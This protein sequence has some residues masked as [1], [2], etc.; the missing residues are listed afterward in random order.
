MSSVMAAWA[1]NQNTGSNTG[2][3]WVKKEPILGFGDSW[4]TIC[5]LMRTCVG[6]EVLSCTVMLA[7]WRS[8]S[9]ARLPEVF[10]WVSWVSQLFWIVLGRNFTLRKLIHKGWISSKKVRQWH[11]CLESWV[12]TL[13]PSGVMNTIREAVAIVAARSLVGETSLWEETVSDAVHSGH[14]DQRVT[15]KSTQCLW[16]E[17]YLINFCG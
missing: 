3:R 5:S 11:K 16:G 9:G 6:M 7:E 2:L 4:R 8:G 13:T 1:S 15:F 14:R 17:N 10:G 12:A